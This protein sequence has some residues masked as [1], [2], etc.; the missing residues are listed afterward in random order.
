MTIAQ[1]LKHYDTL[2]KGSDGVYHYEYSKAFELLKN[3]EA[4]DNDNPIVQNYLGECY[5]YG[6]G[7]RK[8]INTAIEYFK[9]SIV[10]NYYKAYY[11][12]GIMYEKKEIV[13]NDENNE[14]N[15]YVD[16]Y[17]SYVRSYLYNSS[18]IKAFVKIGDLLAFVFLLLYETQDDIQE[19]LV[20][21]LQLYLKAIE[22]ESGDGYYRLANILT[23]TFYMDNEYRDISCAISD[24]G[25]NI[26]LH[27]AYKSAID[28]DPLP[29]PITLYLKAAERGILKSLKYISAKYFIN[30]D[31]TEMLWWYWWAVYYNKKNIDRR[32]ESH[33]NGDYMLSRIYKEMSLHADKHYYKVAKSSTDDRVYEEVYK[34]WF[35]S[36]LKAHNRKK[37]KTTRG[38]QTDSSRSENETRSNSSSIKVQNP[39]VSN[40]DTAIIDYATIL[41]E[42]MVFAKDKYEKLIN[43]MKNAKTKADGEKILKD[44][45]NQPSN[46]SFSEYESFYKKLK[47]FQDKLQ[48]IVLF[49]ENYKSTYK[50]TVNK[51]IIFYE[52]HK[53][54]LDFRKLPKTRSSS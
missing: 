10:H 52:T 44:F 47:Y 9:K 37:H 13:N 48:R 4:V 39:R 25:L 53:P 30:R 17:N 29:E 41:N 34:K 38:S 1:A 35:L 26:M 22:N 18:F 43:D 3:A 2:V 28:P 50:E 54:F 20:K 7:V 46:I 45:T 51:A 11:N 24:E 6:R 27:I 40:I 15:K 23:D 32:I 16:A 31:Y 14:A 19:N 21:S 42:Q 33:I 36:S 49:T 12:I 5:Y 8:N